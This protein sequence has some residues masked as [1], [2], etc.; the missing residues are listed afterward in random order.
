MATKKVLFL[1]V[2]VSLLSCERKNSWELDWEDQVYCD[3]ACLPE[4]KFNVE[5]AELVEELPSSTG[6]GG[7]ATVSSISLE[8]HSFGFNLLVNV[9]TVHPI[10]NI[11]LDL[12]EFLLKYPVAAGTSSSENPYFTIEACNVL[13]ESQGISC[14]ERCLEACSCVT[15]DDE[16]ASQAALQ[17]CAVTCSAHKA[18]NNW[19]DELYKNEQDFAYK[20]YNG[21]QVYDSWVPGILE[22]IPMCQANSCE[23][24]QDGP[25]SGPREEAVGVPFIG[26]DTD[27]ALS[28]ISQMGSAIYVETRAP[29]SSSTL[30]SEP[31]P[32]GDICTERPQGVHNTTSCP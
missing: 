16:Y 23:P 6:E 28:M 27:A 32:T 24:Y 17:G 11:Y 3:G 21:H 10:E 20:I 8:E 18:L 22:Q 13:A 19:D 25:S 9:S 26:T 14:T 12:G 7:E 29:S 15:C 4:Q 31:F 5:N 30:V 1:L 2:F